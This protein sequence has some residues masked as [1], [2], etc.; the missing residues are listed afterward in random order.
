VALPTGVESA[1]ERCAIRRNIQGFP[2][3]EINAAWI[4]GVKALAR[5]AELSGFKPAI[6]LG[7]L[8]WPRARGL[9]RSVFFAEPW[10]A[11][12]ESLVA[13]WHRGGSAATAFLPETRRFHQQDRQRPRSARMVLE[14]LQAA[15]LGWAEARRWPGFELFHARAAE[16]SMPSVSEASRAAG[17][18]GP[19]GAARC[20]NVRPGEG[21]GGQPASKRRRSAAI[22]A[23]D[24]GVVPDPTGPMGPAASVRVQM[25]PAPR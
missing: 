14:R 18:R 22:L 12:P 15:A 17:P 2:S 19:P 9:N 11:L 7:L 21:R 10:L 1:E 13:G 23:G 5:L 16:G 8:I 24:G 25:R 6:L 20:H 3:W 4:S